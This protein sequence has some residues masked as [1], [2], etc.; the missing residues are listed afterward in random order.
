[1]IVDSDGEG[2]ILSEEVRESGSEL[3]CQIYSSSSVK[4]SQ[5]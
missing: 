4:Q 3:D 1:M 5:S 2:K